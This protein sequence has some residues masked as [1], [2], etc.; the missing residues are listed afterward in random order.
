[1]VALPDSIVGDRALGRTYALQK[2]DLLDYLAVEVGRCCMHD[3]DGAVQG[4]EEAR[5]INETRRRTLAE[6][7]EWVIEH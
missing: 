6:I 1:M 2:K 4:S 3:K 7:F 5:I